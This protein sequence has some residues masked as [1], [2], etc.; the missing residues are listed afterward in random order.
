[1]FRVRC[2]DRR[3]EVA[4][5]LRDESRAD[6]RFTRRRHEFGITAGNKELC[7]VDE[8]KCRHRIPP[9]RTTLCRHLEQVLHQ[10]IGDPTDGGKGL[11]RPVANQDGP[12]VEDVLQP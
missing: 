5:V 4:D 6:P 11:E 8:E 7:F 1:M 2:S 12:M 3:V 9:H 10:A